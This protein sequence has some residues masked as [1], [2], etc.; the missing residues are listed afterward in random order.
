MDNKLQVRLPDGLLEYVEN[1]AREMDF[2]PSA[3]IRFLIIKDKESAGDERGFWKDAVDKQISVM[4][5]RIEE[6]R[7]VK[8]ELEKKG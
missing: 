7:Q 4:G 5:E 8:N 1:R 6:L 2:T 3:F